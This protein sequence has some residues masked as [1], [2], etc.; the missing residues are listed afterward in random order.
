MTISKACEDAQIAICN[1]YNDGQANR[2][3]ALQQAFKDGAA[4]MKRI[5]AHAF[6]SVGESKLSGNSCAKVIDGFHLPFRLFNVVIAPDETQAAS[7]SATAHDEGGS[8]Q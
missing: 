2:E 7:A 1:R 6:R 4:E 3:R 8:A 5:A